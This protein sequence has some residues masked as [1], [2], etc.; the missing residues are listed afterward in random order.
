MSEAAAGQCAER[1]KSDADFLLRIA[2]TADEQERM[3]VIHS[4]GF[5]CTWDEVVAAYGP[6][7][8]E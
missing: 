4:E 7:L 6:P 5:D 2:I 3:A 1:M 8:D